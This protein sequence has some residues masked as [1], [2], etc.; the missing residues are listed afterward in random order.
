MLREHMRDIPEPRFPEG[1]SIR[2]VRAGEGALRTDVQRDA[3]EMFAV[4]DG[5]FAREF[6]DDLPATERRCFFVLD[7]KGAAF[8]AACDELPAARDGR[9]ERIH[10]GGTEAR[11]T[12][13]Y[14]QVF[15]RVSVSPW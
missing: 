3:G 10:H 1:F 11:R 12:A 6:G 4:D 15:L 9:D 7:S 13:N 8:K 5:L 2:A 14:S